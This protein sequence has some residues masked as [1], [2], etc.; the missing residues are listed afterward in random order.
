[1]EAESV[2]ADEYIDRFITPAG[3]TGLWRV[4]RRGM[5]GKMSAE[6]RK[7]LDITMADIQFRP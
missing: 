4:E 6:E 3:L 7:Q 1:M 5:G 2:T